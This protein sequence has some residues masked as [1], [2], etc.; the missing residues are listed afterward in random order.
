MTRPEP[1]VPSES[2]PLKADEPNATA[3]NALPLIGADART[4]S[5]RNGAAT[6]LRHKAERRTE[7]L[8]EIRAQ[9]AAGTLVIRQMTVADHEAASQS[10]RRTGARNAAR[11]KLARKLRGREPD[12][13]TRE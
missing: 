9:I 12:R 11:V 8:E 4:R 13:R 1:A 10:A 5:G 3:S 7:R 6:V 2:P